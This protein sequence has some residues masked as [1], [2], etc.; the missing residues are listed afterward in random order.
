MTIGC[1]VVMGKRDGVIGRDIIEFG[2]KTQEIGRKE[3]NP[4]SSKEDNGLFVIL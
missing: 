1:F 4:L 3:N 2:D